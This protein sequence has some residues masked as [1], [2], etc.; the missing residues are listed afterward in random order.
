MKVFKNILYVAE[1]TV[2]QSAAVERAVTLAENNQSKL[3]I[4]DVFPPVADD[5]RA[6]TMDYHKNTLES[7]IAPYRK[8]LEIRLDVMMGTPFLEVVRAVLRNEHDLVI[9]TAENPDFLKRLF[10][11]NDMHLL[12]KCPCPAWLMKPREKSNYN[13]I[14]AA[15]DF[16]LLSPT[17]SEQSLNLE[18]L[19]LAASLAL[20]DSASL[21]IVHAWEAFAERTMI[22]R[23]DISYESIAKHTNQEFA[24]HQKS[25]DRLMETMRNRVGADVFDRLSPRLHLPKGPAKTMIA[26][27]AAGL[28]A[29]LVV[30]GTVARTG[31]SG[32]I[33]G[34]TAEAILDQLTCSVLAV[35]PPGFTT[36]V[37]LDT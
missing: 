23:G 37:K 5:Y 16:D 8:R 32:L 9:K 14:V 3:T 27:S 13:T 20:T 11:S 24:L 10:G 2:D 4:I 28:S 36:P 29:D 19:E 35:K 33:I 12:R 22:M 25:L 21:H 15:V 30:M 7:V 6:N 34:N 31:I 1:P 18:I 17:A 26:T